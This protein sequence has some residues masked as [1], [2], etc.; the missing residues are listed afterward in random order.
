MLLALVLAAAPAAAAEFRI[1]D[2][3]MTMRDGAPLAVSYYMPEPLEAGRRYPVLLELLPYRKDDAF[4]GRDYPLHGYFAQQGFV[5]VKADVRGTG[6]SGGERP[7]REYS[8]AEVADA[9]ELVARLASA[10]WSNGK[11]GMWGISWGGFN[12]LIT[13]M[14][15]P[16]ALG[17]VLAAHASDDLYHDDVHYVDGVLHVNEYELAIDHDNALPRPPAYALDEAYFRDRFEARPWLFSK[18]EHIRDGPWWRS[19]SLRFDCSRVTVPVYLIGGLLDT[20]RDTVPRLL[21]CLK[22]PVKAEIGPWNHAWPDNGEPGPNYEWRRQAARWFKHWLSGEENGVEREPR[23]V[24]FARDGHAPDKGL[25]TVPGRWVAADWPPRAGTTVTLYPGPAALTSNI[26]LGG[27]RSFSY[28]PAAGVEAGHYWGE[29][30]GDQSPSDAKELVF[31]SPALEDD[32][33]A[34]GLPRVFLRARS[35][36][37]LAHWVAR[38]EDLAPDGASALVTGAALN[39]SQR[40]SRTEP[41]ALTPGM[42]ADFVLDLHFTTWRFKKGHRIR[43]ALANGSFPMLWPLPS[44]VESTVLFG[45]NTRLEL[46]VP[47]PGLPD[48]ALPPPEPRLSRAGCEDLGSRGWPYE[49]VLSTDA[50]T[51]DAVVTWSGEDL[52][53]VPHATVTSRQVMRYRVPPKDP[54]A[55]SWDGEAAT[56]FALNGRLLRLETEASIRAVPGAFEATLT[57]RILEDGEAVREKSFADR[58]PRDFQ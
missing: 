6:S 46:P 44:P 20:Y 51:G 56:D 49:S 30:T 43:L 28:D 8:G 2:T 26:P 52:Y 45:A 47:S 42:E 35:S 16:P 18:L 53:R 48:A 33:E 5:S 10:P 4:L 1:I 36:A 40:A 22:V 55:A 9:E 54:G 23:L 29:L 27:G 11:V 19:K 14:E 31:D 32:L 37:A 34:A 13:A 15:R 17:A 58:F 7:D 25:K 38:L 41:S 39:G 50:A 57:R 3:T 21:E 12:A 24:Y